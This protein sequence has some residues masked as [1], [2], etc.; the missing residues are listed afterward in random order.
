MSSIAFTGNRDYTDTGALYR[1]LDGVS[2]DTYYFGG[3]RGA[4]TDALQYIAKTQPASERIVVVPNRL[5]DQPVAV[6]SI[7]QR[8]ATRI[9]ELGNS[10]PGR[11]QVRNQYMVNHADRVVAFTDGRKT[12][13]TFNTIT[14]ANTQGKGVEL[15]E[16]VN[17]DKNIV[18]AMNERELID[19]LG[20]C[21]TQKVPELAVKG[22]TIA[23][24]KKMPRSSWPAVLGR[25]RRLR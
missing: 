16:W 3:A 15:I 20:K 4:D 24:M 19:W 10:G 22:M 14:Y 17:V 8:D 11:Y 1:G 18:M 2:A 21:E 23:A 6:R 12:G 25:L 9:I 5:A 13:G 7:I